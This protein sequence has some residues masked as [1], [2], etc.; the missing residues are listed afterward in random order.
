MEKKQN[1][2]LIPF[3][4]VHDVGIRLVGQK[5]EERGH[6]VTLVPPDLPAEEIIKRAQEHRYDFILVSRTMGYGLAEVLG[7]LVDYLEAAGLRARTKL[8][9]GGKAATPELAAELGFDAGFPPGAP[10]DEVVAY[11]E[12]SPL[13]PGVKFVKRAKKDITERYSYS[14]KQAEIGRL[15]DTIADEAIG[16]A[17]DKTTPGIER[18]ELRRAMLEDPTNERACLSSYLS[19][20]DDSIVRHYTDHVPIKGTRFLCPEETQILDKLH[21]APP[22]QK[23][24]HSPRHPLLVIFVGS[25][26]PVMDAAHILAADGWGIDGV[27]LV[28]PSWSAR[29]EG[30]MRGLVAQEEDGTVITSANVELIKKYLNPE[31]YFQ[32]R[33][34]RGI[35]TPEMSVYGAHFS[36]DFGKITPVYGSLHGGTDPERLVADAIYAIKTAAGHGFP[37]DIPGND[38]L[39]GTPPDKVFAGMLTTAAIARKIGARPVLKPLLCFSP[40]NMLHGQMDNNYVDYNFGKIRAL[41]SILDAPVWCGEPVGFNTHEDDRSQ[42]A[43]TTALHSVLAASAGADI[44]TFASTDESYSRGPIVMPSRTDTFNALRSA[45]RFFGDATITP[46]MKADEYRDEILDGIHEVLQRVVDHGSFVKS[47]YSGQYGS[48]DDGAKPGRAG[49]GTV[50]KKTA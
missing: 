42:S 28:D 2:L 19:L 41:Q 11:I 16:W 3:D 4:P 46:T 34:H 23:I 50:T 40:Y 36:I 25:G 22:T 8:V 43:I 7:R 37:F 47:I 27:I 17:E 29:I 9:L 14:Y 18:A 31:L 20:C 35:N 5:L 26:C 12:G 10:V 30:L 39:S 38:E 1:L 6:H 32:L 33:M 24:R 13:E 15:L 21:S 49:R 48:V 45:Y 44:L